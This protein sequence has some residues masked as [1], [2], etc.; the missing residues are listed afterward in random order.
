MSQTAQKIALSIHL[1]TATSCL[2]RGDFK[3]TQ[4]ALRNALKI[5]NALEHS[6]IKKLIFRAMNHVRNAE[7]IAA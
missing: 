4:L 7:R 1:D 5:A 6:P 3:A 2:K